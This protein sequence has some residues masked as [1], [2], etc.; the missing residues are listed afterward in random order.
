[1]AIATILLNSNSIDYEASI[2]VSEHAVYRD[3]STI[4]CNIAIATTDCI[5]YTIAI[6]MLL[7]IIIIYL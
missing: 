2:I 7:F 5:I 4:V 3:N 6:I 1:M